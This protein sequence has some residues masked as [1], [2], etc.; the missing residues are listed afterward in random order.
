MVVF[1]LIEAEYMVLTLVAI[2]AIYLRLPLTKVGL[3]DKNG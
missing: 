1:S 3:L 2:E